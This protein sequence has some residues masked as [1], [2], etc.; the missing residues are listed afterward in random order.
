MSENLNSTLTGIINTLNNHADVINNLADKSNLN[1]LLTVGIYIIFII[2]G[3]WKIFCLINKKFSIR[4]E[5]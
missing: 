4:G 2:I 1:M 3:L 5:K